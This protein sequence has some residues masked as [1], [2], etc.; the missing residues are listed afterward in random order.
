M[1]MNGVQH[2]SN[3]DCDGDSNVNQYILEPDF[4]RSPSASGDTTAN[5]QHRKSH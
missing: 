4:G 1:G 5:E 2:S 3:Y